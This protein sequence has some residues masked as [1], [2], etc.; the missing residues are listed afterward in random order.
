MSLNL[1]DS[2]KTMH[3]YRVTA[4]GKKSFI[5]SIDRVCGCDAQG[6]KNRFFTWL[7]KEIA[8]EL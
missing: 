1:L 8:M 6:E 3:T 4:V 7:C 2:V 5:H